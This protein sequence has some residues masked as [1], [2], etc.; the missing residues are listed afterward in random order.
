MVEYRFVYDNVIR[1]GRTIFQ[2]TNA[3]KEAHSLVMA[4]VDPDFPPIDEQLH[5]DD[6]MSIP[7]FAQIFPRGPGESGTFA[8]DIQPGRR[9]VFL[10]LVGDATGTSHALKGMNSEFVAASAGVSTA[11]PAPSAVPR[12]RAS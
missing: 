2:V 7:P 9:Y 6:R 4:P 11:N 10:C 1:P 12:S 3:G 8:I 5:G